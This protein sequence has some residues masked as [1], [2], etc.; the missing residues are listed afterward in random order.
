MTHGFS[1]LLGSV[2]VC[3]TLGHWVIGRG[4]LSDEGVSL[5]HSE[6]YTSCYENL[7]F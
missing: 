1:I 6:Y 7:Y 5:V 3:T 4:H 2:F